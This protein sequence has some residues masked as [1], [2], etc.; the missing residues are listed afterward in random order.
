MWGL[1]VWFD[2]ANEL[3]FRLMGGES[4]AIEYVFAGPFFP[5]FWVIDSIVEIAKTPPVNRLP[6]FRFVSLVVAPF[7][8]VHAAFLFLG[9][10]LIRIAR[11]IIG[12]VSYGVDVFKIAFVLYLYPELQWW[13]VSIVAFA[14][15]F[16]PTVAVVVPCFFRNDSYDVFA[17][18]VSFSL[19]TIS[20]IARDA[21][22]LKRTKRRMP[23]QLIRFAYAAHAVAFLTMR[24]TTYAHDLV[25]QTNLAW[26]RL[27]TPNGSFEI[28]KSFIAAPAPQPS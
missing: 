15:G 18:R 21:T 25:A 14:I 26:T 2:A 7:R 27:T 23:I 9:V 4:N 3:G 11:V 20:W 24:T 12:C 19:V 5:L 16:H 17:R 22:I 28:V 6:S 13:I 1:R 8:F 10:D